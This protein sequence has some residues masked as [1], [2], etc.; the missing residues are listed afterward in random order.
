[1]FNIRLPRYVPHMTI[2]RIVTNRSTEKM[3]S[4]GMLRHMALVRTDVSE[5]H[6]LH[7]QGAIIP[8]QRASVASY[9]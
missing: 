4:S 7:H 3:P 9:C 2:V 5:E 1:M 6:R 8:S